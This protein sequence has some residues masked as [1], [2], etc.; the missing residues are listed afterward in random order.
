MKNK[1]ILNTSMQAEVLTLDP[2]KNGG[3]I[4]SVILF[5]LFNGLTKFKKNG[6]ISLS[7]AKSYKIS[8]D[9]KKYIFYL[10]DNIKWSDGKEITS[11][12]FK[13]CWEKILIPS[14]PSLCTHLLYP[15]VNAEEI[16]TGKKNIDSLGVDCM[17][18][19][20]LIINL[21]HPTP[22]FLSLTS[23][24]LFFPFPYHVEDFSSVNPEKFVC[25]GPFKLKKWIK[26]KEIILEKNPFYWNKKKISFDTINIRIID[27]KTHNLQMFE[28]GQLDWINSLIS[29]IPPENISKTKNIGGTTF[30][31]FNTKKFPFNNKNIRKAFNCSINREDI[32]KN[33]HLKKEQIATR[34]I[35]PVMCKNKNLNLIKDND[36]TT[37]KELFKKGI[38]ELNIN[39]K[40]LKI[41]LTFENTYKKLADLLKNRWEKLFN[42]KISLEPLNAK[43]AIVRLH[44]KQFQIAITMWSL[45][46]DDPLNILE[47]F[48]HKNYEKNYSNWE[49]QKYISLLESL[50]TKKNKKAKKFILK[51]AEKLLIEE[52]PISPIYHHN[53]LIL[54][55]KKTKKIFLGPLGEIIF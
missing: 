23:F 12:D 13:K 35:P 47:R 33:L 24:Y 28:N 14:F 15:I 2:R 8:K 37:A 20:T 44:K 4:S 31:T 49:N 6:S 34:C 43:N 7:L 39:S 32:I 36:I 16:K 19:K 22:Y 9:K 52:N 30:C 29:P 18:D 38:Q 53:Y 10:K 48:K 51:E 41:I 54:K 50:H 40:N 55:N 26:N 5:M 17:D 3:H 11:Y 46:Y 45:F 1:K 27:D 25:N 21:N 42:I